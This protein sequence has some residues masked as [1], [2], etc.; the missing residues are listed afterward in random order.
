MNKYFFIIL[1]IIIL[2]FSCN[3][4]DEKYKTSYYNYSVKR[5]DIENYK[6]INVQKNYDY[7]IADI[8]IDDL[9]Y[10][11]VY[12]IIT[13]VNSTK[14]LYKL[15]KDT[16]NIV[17]LSNTIKDKEYISKFNENPFAYIDTKDNVETETNVETFDNKLNSSNILKNSIAVGD[18]R[19]FYDKDNKKVNA[20][21]RYGK[22]I[23]GITLNIWVENKYW[24]TTPD[25]TNRVKNSINQNMLNKL[26]DKFL[27][28][29][30]EDIYHWVSNVFGKEWGDHNF[31]YMIPS[32]EAGNINIL[33]YDID[34]YENSSNLSTVMVGFFYTRD[35]FKKKM[36]ATSNEM[37]MFYVNASYFSDRI[38]VLWDINDRYPSEIISVLGH[39][40]QHMINFYQKAIK[41]G[42]GK[43]SDTWLNEM[44][45]MVT[46]D[47]LSN[48]LNISGPR[49][50]NGNIPSSIP[51]NT[52]GRLPLFNRYNSEDLTK[53]LEDDDVLRSYS[54]NY[55]F[56]AYIARNFGGI[57]LFNKIVTENSDTN[58]MAIVN[59]VNSLNGTS[60]T[61][62]S[63]LQ[64][65]GIAVILSD[66]VITDNSIKYRY[67]N[68]N[69]WFKSTFNSYTYNLGSVNLYDYI[70]HYN[71]KGPYFID[72]RNS[73][74]I[75]VK[76]NNNSNCYI[77]VEEKINGSLY[78]KVNLSR[79]QYITILLKR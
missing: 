13:T 55:A 27:N 32:S 49:G 47:I 64:K 65:W 23:N 38:G 72:A 7:E 10:D 53:W 6:V 28:N 39:E 20:T 35:S 8:R 19:I 22:T 2:F 9:S 1:S 45:S 60:E 34:N 43:S 59:S 70:D 41:T 33:L 56:G 73:I 66:F 18:Q 17:S 57:E 11:N 68:G 24:Y 63:L 12:F 62:L 71:K 76:T 15:N 51:N 69:N 44:C 77:L 29:N 42:T 36:F 16:Q 21:C 26:A 3:P 50:I 54:I 31:N 78:K 61:F 75:E 5:P 74:D 67:N 79:N 46:E 37:L 52:E 4:D 14:S 40:F 58:Y 30:K 48:K 25:N